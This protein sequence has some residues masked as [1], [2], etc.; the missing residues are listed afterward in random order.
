MIPPS[1]GHARCSDC[2]GTGTVYSVRVVPLSP[3]GFREVHY[4]EICHTCK[5]VGEIELE[6]EEE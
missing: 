3:P 1:E 6:E 2:S 5:G 4:P